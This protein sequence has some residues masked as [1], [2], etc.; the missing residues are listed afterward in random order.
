[1]R[2]LTPGSFVVLA[3]VVVC[4]ALVPTG[5]CARVSPGAP[6]PVGGETGGTTGFD[7]SSS[8]T[9]RDA[10]AAVDRLLIST[11]RSVCGDSDRTADEACDDGNTTP[12]DGCSADCHVVEA[13]Y[14]C[15]PAG[16]PCHRIAR[17]GDGVVVL[18]EL[19]DDG[20]H[21]AGD[22]CSATCKIEAGYK[23]ADAPSVCS[24]TT[25]GDGKAEGAESCDKGD[26]VPF[27][28]CSA[29]CQ[30]EPDC[31]AGACLSACGDGIVVGEACDDGNSVDGDGCSSTCKIEPGFTCLQPPLG[32]KMLV[33]VV[34]RDF[35][36]KMPADFQVLEALGRTTALVGLVKP[37]L[38]AAGKPVFTGTIPFAMSYITSAATFGQWYRDTPGVNHATASKLTLWNNGKGAYVNRY[39][40]NGE[41]WPVTV[42]AYY[43]GNVGSEILDAAGMPTPCTSTVATNTDCDKYVA[44]GYTMVS[45]T[46]MGTNYTAV[47][48]S[49]SLDGTPFFFPVDGDTFSPPAERAIA[50]YGPPYGDTGYPAEK[51]GALHNFSFTSEVRYWFQYDATKTYT[52]DF[53]GDDDVWLFINKKLAVDLGGIHSAVQGS[54]TFGAGA[55]AAGSAKFGLM[56]GQVYEVAVFQ[57]ERRTDSSSYRLTLSGF[58]AAASECT[59]VCGD[60][61]LGIGEE[62]DDGT[63]PGGY[64]QCGPGC[65]LGE[66]CGD[67]V[68]QSEFEN[69][70]DGVNI[71]KPC[72]SGCKI[73]IIL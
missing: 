37:D 42:N 69:C 56:N 17:C 60:G 57:A 70:D 38:D 73:L 13:G 23:C 62:C 7:A 36:A 44:L 14:S 59:P 1:M 55:G 43:C 25:C 8:T 11:S 22:G 49:A 61:I 18:P 9:F 65:K 6:G 33:P 54:V 30:S 67:G 66:Y 3:L 31:S 2:F 10:S 35:R 32:E 50:R 46:R 41:P 63:N 40:A 24:R 5:G 52:L 71:G 34:Y 68:V 4:A 16:K 53:T 45:C 21:T 39:G 51:G 28:G 47:F 27:D 64:G 26:A 72:P 15:V 19:C 12:G 48:Q 20:N 29:E 58:S